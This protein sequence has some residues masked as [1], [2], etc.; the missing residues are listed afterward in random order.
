M[1]PFPV[2]YQKDE[3]QQPVTFLISGGGIVG[4]T[5]ALSLHKHTGIVPVVYEKYSQDKFHQ[6]VGAGMGMYPNGLRVLRDISP[7]LLQKVRA[8]GK[9]Y[10]H[11][12]WV[13]HCGTEIAK[14]HENVLHQGDQEDVQS[15]GIGR[16]RFHKFLWDRQR[17]IPKD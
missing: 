17:P 4:L 8:L 11:R 3:E 12:R 15:F 6:C 16:W 5:L 10:L 9:P 13:K 2:V 1:A 7:K 14:G